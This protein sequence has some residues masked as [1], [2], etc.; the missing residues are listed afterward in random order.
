MKK[1]K[2]SIIFI[3]LIGIVIFI[4]KRELLRRSKHEVFDPT[5]GPKFAHEYWLFLLEYE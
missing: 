1:Q 4:R 3:I 5:F 2:K